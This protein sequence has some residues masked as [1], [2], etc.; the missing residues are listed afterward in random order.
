MLTIMRKL[1]SSAE[2]SWPLTRWWRSFFPPKSFMGCTDPDADGWSGFGHGQPLTDTAIKDAEKKVRRQMRTGLSDAIFAQ[3]SEPKNAYWTKEE[4]ALSG[5]EK[6][7]VVIGQ[8]QNWC[9][10][11]RKNSVSSGFFTPAGGKRNNF[12]AKPRPPKTTQ[13]NVFFLTTLIVSFAGLV[14]NL[15]P[16][17]LVLFHTGIKIAHNISNSFFVVLPVLGTVFATF[18][19]EKDRFPVRLR[20]DDQSQVVPF[21]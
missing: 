20:K 2:G 21:Y 4:S 14:I 8:R 15:I 16:L 7:P 3:F 12:F 6:T 13:L 18:C 10:R 11:E 17:K 1:T 9:S 5:F 19:R